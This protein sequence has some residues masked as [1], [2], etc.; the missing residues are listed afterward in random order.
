MLM[1]LSPAAPFAMPADARRSCACVF[2]SF[3][4]G[5]DARR[6]DAGTL[7]IVDAR[8]ARGAGVG[9]GACESELLRACTGLGSAGAE[10]A[11]A[12]TT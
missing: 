7:V 5:A 4:S 11:V 12:G 8:R 3:P 6:G 2:L 10:P 1:R 9:A